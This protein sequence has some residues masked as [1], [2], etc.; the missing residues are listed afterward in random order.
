MKI[1]Y[2]VNARIPTEKAHGYQI[3]KMCESLASCGNEVDLWLPTRANPIK[4]DPLSHYGLKKNFTIRYI[5]S[6]DFLE[7]AKYLGPVSFWLQSGLFYFKL[8]FKKIDKNVIIYTRDPEIVW[9]FSRK[10]LKVVYECHEWF[11]RHTA[12]RLSFIKKAY[13]LVTT[14]S[15]IKK[16]FVCRGF[17][18]GGILVAPNGIDLD[19]FDLDIEKEEAMKRLCLPVETVEKFQDKKIL[20][21]TGT[22]KTKGFEKGIADIL[23]ALKVLNDDGALFLAVG[24]DESDIDYYSR[25]AET[26][27]VAKQT[28]FLSRVSQSRL[29]LWQKA[30]DILLMPFPKIAHYEFF[31]SPLKMFEYMSAGRP[32]IASDLPSIREIL[33]ENNCLFCEPDKPDSLAHK[34]KII[35]AD[36]ILV[37]KMGLRARQDVSHY[38]WQERAKKII[39]FINYGRIF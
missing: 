31:M 39:N 35:L 25:M 3:V 38:S 33:N 12:L 6:F 1:I 11:A 28:M 34:I 24:G 30:S 9:L 19:V 20:L 10:G 8:I 37:K 21:Y 18:E 17:S 13:Y 7:F 26:L 27:G 29:A 2:I 14:N 36:T 22:F 16:E 4:E 15:F 23:K 5:K 32:I